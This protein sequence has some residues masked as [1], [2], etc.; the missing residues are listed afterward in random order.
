MGVQHRAW[1]QYT[2]TEFIVVDMMPILYNFVFHR[3]E[4]LHKICGLHKKTKP[5]WLGK[6]R[7]RDQ[8]EFDDFKDYSMTDAEITARAAAWLVQ[9]QR[10]DPV[11]YMSAGTIAKDYFNFPQRLTKLPGNAGYEVPYIESLI[12]QT[13]SAGRSEC[14]LN[15]F[16]Q[17]V[18][19]HDVQSLYPLSIVA[20]RC[21]QIDGVTDVPDFEWSSYERSIP[22]AFTLPS[23]MDG[24]TIPLYG[25]I[26]GSFFV[27]PEKQDKWGLAQRGEERNYY[28]VG[29]IHGTFSTFDLCAAHAKPLA[30]EKVWRPIYSDQALAS[31]N[32]YC[33]TLEHKLDPGTTIE[34]AYKLKAVLNAASGKLC[35]SHPTASATSNYPAYSM[36]IGYS[37]LIMSRL[38]DRYDSEII[39]ID[40]DSIL[41]RKKMLG[42][43]D[44][45]TDGEQSFAVNLKDKGHGNVASFRSKQYVLWDESLGYVPGVNPKYAAHGWDFFTDHFKRLY[46]GKITYLNTGREV[47]HT[48]LT[49]HDD[50]KWLPLGHWYYEPAILTLK[51]ISERV[52]CDSKRVRENDDSYGLVIQRKCAG[53]K[54]RN[55]Q[56]ELLVVRPRNLG[57]RAI[58]LHSH[59]TS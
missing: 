27:D 9:E 42:Q 8:Y 23:E 46:W 13:T 43:Q 44:E 21:L 47:K 18:T 37:H 2:S 25:W 14:F 17:D 19:Y 49:N 50:A 20:T 48:L 36:L 35:Q 15:G 32:K 39:S 10:V 26:R 4:D 54:A 56:E 58:D 22:D 53:S 41:G 51:T 1:I 11:K 34:Q 55:Y 52:R 12:D 6:R 33:E 16:I 31:H 5:N 3:L 28:C 7:W 45:V 29:R 40:T 59:S 24:S 57:K 30:I 38:F